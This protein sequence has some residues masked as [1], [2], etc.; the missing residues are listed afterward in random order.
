MVKEDIIFVLLD[1]LQDYEIDVYREGVEDED[2]ELTE[3]S[4][5]IEAWVIEEFKRI[6]LDTARSVLEQDV[7]DLVNVPIWKKKPFWR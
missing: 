7:K 6:G 5:E 2:V 1:S 3:F 4:D